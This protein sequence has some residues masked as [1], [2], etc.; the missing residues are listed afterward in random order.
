M[1]Q[2][3][4]WTLEIL[5]AS[6]NVAEFTP[7]LDAYYALQIPRLKA[8]G[9]PDVDPQEVIADFWAH[10]DECMPPTG[11]FVLARDDTGIVGC[12]ALHP[13]GDGAAEL[14]RLY[15]EPRA[16][17]TGLGRALVQERIAVARQLGYTRLYCDTLKNSVE[18][19]GLYKTL[20]FELCGPYPGDGTLAVFPELADKILFY[21]RSI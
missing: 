3:N 20:G 17:G 15:V 10:I 9:G 8:I 5:D 7:V 21:T 11:C 16:R 13:L 12:G 19:Q 4:P 2:P 1:P 6:P 14:K 18:M